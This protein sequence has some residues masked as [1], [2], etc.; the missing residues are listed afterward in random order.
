M[1]GIKS[2][3]LLGAGSCLVPF[4]VG[5]PGDTGYMI[6]LINAQVLYSLHVLN[7]NAV[8]R[9]QVKTPALDKIANTMQG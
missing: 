3:R 5:L 6:D 9:H 7:S 2:D 8:L 1:R 4:Q